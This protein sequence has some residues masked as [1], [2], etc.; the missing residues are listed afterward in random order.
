MTRN[1]RRLA[2]LYDADMRT[3]DKLTARLAATTKIPHPLR[4]VVYADGTYSCPHE[5][6]C[7]NGPVCIEAYARGVEPAQLSSHTGH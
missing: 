7:W 3:R 4:G 2:D 6:R 1:F 5:P